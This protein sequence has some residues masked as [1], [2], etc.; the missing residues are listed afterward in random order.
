MGLTELKA[1]LKRNETVHSELKHQAQAYM[2][3]VISDELKQPHARLDK[4][5]SIGSQAELGD[6]C[7]LN[8][9][10]ALN[11]AGN[12]HL[13]RIDLRNLLKYKPLSALEPRE[14]QSPQLV[15]DQSTRNFAT[16][17]K[18][19]HQRVGTDHELTGSLYHASSKSALRGSLKPEARSTQVTPIRFLAK[20]ASLKRRSDHLDLPDI[21]QCSPKKQRAPSRVDTR[22]FQTPERS[23][24]S[25]QL[26]LKYARAKEA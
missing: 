12:Y 25:S 24:R 19:S 5:K 9:C 23:L 13:K 16:P 26:K 8:V 4:L 18:S 15:P 11:K 14:E 3:T 21:S 10:E 17:A 20:E 7:A 6:K 2:Q 1:F 22:R